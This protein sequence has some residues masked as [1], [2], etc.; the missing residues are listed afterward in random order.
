[1]NEHKQGEKSG[2]IP[3]NSAKI[4]RTSA[5]DTST[6]YVIR[7]YD[8]QEMIGEDQDEDEENKDKAAGLLDNEGTQSPMDFILFPVSYL[9]QG[10]NSDSDSDSDSDSN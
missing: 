5:K 6:E 1:M 9:V 4:L 2:R 3:T 8:F 7:I 10:C